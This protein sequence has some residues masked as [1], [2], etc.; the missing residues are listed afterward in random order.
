MNPLQ[1]KWHRVTRLIQDVLDELSSANDSY[2]VLSP[3]ES[4]AAL[5]WLANHFPIASWGRI[6]WSDVTE[7]V[8]VP[9][10]EKGEELAKAFRAMCQNHQLADPP[11]IVA[12]S[13]ALAPAIQTSLVAVCHHAEA[14]FDA[15]FD[16]WI[17]CETHGWCIEV[18]HEG[19]LCFGQ[20][21]V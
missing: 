10:E 14:M 15:D 9:W 4:D 20:S 1:K 12:W 19:E 8:C 7:S 13:N 16:T 2:R 5:A 6:L 17:I 3:D 21:S 11:V 18:Y